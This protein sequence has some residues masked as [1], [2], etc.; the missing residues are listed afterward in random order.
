MASAEI[1]RGTGHRNAA[2]LNET[3]TAVARI[4][5]DLL[6][7]DGIVHPIRSEAERMAS[8]E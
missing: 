6:K 3:E 7:L 2:A 4:W 5:Q 1:G 8:Y